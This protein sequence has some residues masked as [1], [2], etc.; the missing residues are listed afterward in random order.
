MN[1]T[2][3]GAVIGLSLLFG[4]VA[5]A[6][7]KKVGLTVHQDTYRNMTQETTVTEFAAKV[8]YSGVVLGVLPTLDWET[9]E[10]SDVELALSY[11]YPVTDQINI[12]PYGELHYDKDLERGDRFLGFKTT[13]RF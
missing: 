11:T 3:F 7:E 12:I 10:I 6:A 4:S 13:F 8:D 1:K 2:I 9:E 5:H